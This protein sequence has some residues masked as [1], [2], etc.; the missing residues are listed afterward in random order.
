MELWQEMI[1]NSITTVDHLV[2]KFNI[3]KEVAGKLDEFFQARINPYYLSLIRYPGDPIWLQCVPDVKELDD[4]DA[5]DDP[6]H[7]DEM[8]PVP[9]ITHRYPDRALF[10][11]TS[12]C[13]LYCRFCTRK[14]KV[15]DQT[16]ISMRTFESAFKYLEQHTE[17]SDVILSGGDPLMLT[18]TML[19]KILARLREIKH[20]QIIRLGSKMPCVL[21][22]RIT[23]HLVEM[24]KKYHP[25]YCNTHFNHPWEITEESKKACAMLVDAG[26]PV[27][28]QCVLMKGVND[29]PETMKQLMK[30]L[31][32][33]RVRPYY[34]YM[35]D[36]T[37]GANHFRTPIKVGLDIMDKLRGHISGLAVPHFV[38]DAPGGGGK[39]P[40]LPNYVISQ[41]ENKIVLRN[42][43]YNIYEYPDVREGSQI[44]DESMFMR[45]SPR[46]RK[47]LVSKK[48]RIKKIKV[49][50]IQNG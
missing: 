9:N 14:R 44:T 23:P 48:E 27:G 17:I 33:M 1:R 12:Q 28:N 34:I 11:V 7:E 39:I 31:L 36:L 15:G 18:D 8:S 24:L 47:S 3:D 21:P 6:L 43:K 35:A 16:K 2:E 5:E 30:G 25:I 19:E 50:V 29:N 42:F 49:P 38:V 22:H 37:K 13:G 40:L 4:I 46:R 20:I 26:I 32:A 41:D 10:L 45:K